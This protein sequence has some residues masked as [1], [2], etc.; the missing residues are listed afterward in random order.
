MTLIAVCLI[1]GLLA[2]SVYGVWLSNE[3]TK[4]KKKPRA[5]GMPHKRIS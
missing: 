2:G 4:A 1:L 5:A 3:E